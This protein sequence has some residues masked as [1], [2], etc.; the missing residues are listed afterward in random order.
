[1]HFRYFLTPQDLFSGDEST[2]LIPFPSAIP[3][4]THAATISQGNI[5]SPTGQHPLKMSNMGFDPYV[6]QDF[7][8]F[9]SAK[10]GETWTLSAYVKSKLPNT[11]DV[12]MYIQDEIST[13][14]VEKDFPVTTEWTR[15]EFPYKVNTDTNLRIRLDGPTT[16]AEGNV[17]Y[18]DGLQLEKSDDATEFVP[19][20]ENLLLNPEIIITPVERS[21]KEGIKTDQQ[22]N[23]LFNVH[24]GT[25]PIDNAQ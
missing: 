9:V 22:G 15:I 16:S 6:W 4:Y 1:M 23:G 12:Q 7:S 20:S 2:G 21:K 10:E 3:G 14:D 17:I 13:Q 25:Q 5:Q 19:S 24:I 11:S 18:W 8:K